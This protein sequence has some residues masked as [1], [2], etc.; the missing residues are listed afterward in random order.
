MHQD[1]HE[2]LNYLL[3]AIAENVEDYQRKIAAAEQQVRRERERSPSTN[4]ATADTASVGGSTGSEESGQGGFGCRR[5]FV[6]QLFSII[7]HIDPIV[8]VGTPVIRGRILKRDKVF[9]V[10]NGMCRFWACRNEEHVGARVTSRDESF[11]DLSI[12]IDMNSSVTSCLRQFSASETLCHKDKYFCDDE[13]QK[14]TKHSGIASETVQVSGTA[15]EVHQTHL[16]C[17]FPIRVEVVQY[18]GYEAIFNCFPE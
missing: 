3:N 6:T 15:A 11:L 14:A 2:F 18:G 10:R 16:P 1:A 17:C 12:D 8:D 5:H 7:S 13:D 9:D 4:G